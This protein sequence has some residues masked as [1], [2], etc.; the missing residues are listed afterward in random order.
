MAQWAKE[1]ATKPSRSELDAQGP[2]QRLK[3][4][5]NSAYAQK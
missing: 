3:E 4:R 1:L 2:T 5:S